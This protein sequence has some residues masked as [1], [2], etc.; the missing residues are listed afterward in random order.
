MTD[1]RVLLFLLLALCDVKL[2]EGQEQGGVE[3][4]HLG[5]LKFFFALSEYV[6]PTE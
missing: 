2:V 3:A 1:D 6:S 4:L 5:L